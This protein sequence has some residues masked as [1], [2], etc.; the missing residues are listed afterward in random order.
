MRNTQRAIRTE[1]WK[2]TW[3]P[4]IG[5][6]Q[7]FDLRHDPHEMVDLLVSWRT[8]KR[9]YL[10]DGVP[11]WQGEKW[12]P[13]DMRPD[14]TQAEIQAVCDDLHGRLIAHMERNGDPALAEQRPPRP[15]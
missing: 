2:L 9:Q 14:Y 10:A 6:Y 5:R 13:R 8:R 7:L 11:T 3:F 1:R 4:L 12:S 15:L